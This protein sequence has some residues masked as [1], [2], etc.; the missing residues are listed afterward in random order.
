MLRIFQPVVQDYHALLS[1]SGAVCLYYEGKS[2]IPPSTD[3]KR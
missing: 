1:P 2:R 3:G